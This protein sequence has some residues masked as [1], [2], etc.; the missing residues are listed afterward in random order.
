MPKITEMFAFVAEDKE[1]PGDEGV[2]GFRNHYGEWMPLVGA[3][4]DRVSSLKPLA[5]QVSQATGIKYKIL[6]FALV[7]EIK[8]EE[9]K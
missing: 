8:P 6:K 5:D 4:M 9:I 7:G 3:D 2:I 1:L